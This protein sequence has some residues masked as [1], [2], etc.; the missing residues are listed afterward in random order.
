MITLKVPRG[1]RAFPQASVWLI[2]FWDGSLT[3][4]AACVYARTKWDGM[5]KSHLVLAKSRVAPMDGSTVQRMELQGLLQCT[6]LL[7]RVINATKIAPERV[8]IAGDSMCAIMTLRKSGV[9]FRPFFQNR[10]GKFKDTSKT[11]KGR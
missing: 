11:L 6:R 3:A 1:I 2:A 10:V 7:K 4:H 5:V 8:T 9:N